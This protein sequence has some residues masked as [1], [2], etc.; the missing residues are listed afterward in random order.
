[1]AIPIIGTLRKKI[2]LKVLITFIIA[3]P[4]LSPQI[5]VLSLVS[6]GIEYTVLRIFFA[7]IV[8]AST[9]VIIEL[10]YKKKKF[11]LPPFFCNYC[12]KNKG[13][14]YTKT[15]YFFKQLLPF[16]F[17]A[18][19]VN[20]AIELFG[21]TELVSFAQVESILGT[22]IILLIGIPVYFCGGT[23]I[24]LIRPFLM[25]GIIGLGTAAGFSVTSTAICIASIAMLI[26]IIGKKATLVMTTLIFLVSFILATIVNMII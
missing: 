26:K 15:M 7:F 3:A 18:G 6:L 12:Q 23:E 13:D 14:I 9:G 25:H 21:I 17:L 10:L 24:I 2:G 5:I 11:S 22:V 1:M 20:V 19:L 8:A 4:I 16:I